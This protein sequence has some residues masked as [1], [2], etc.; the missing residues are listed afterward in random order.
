MAEKGATR[1]HFE[2]NEALLTDTGVTSL[3][4]YQWKDKKPLSMELSTNEQEHMN[5]YPSYKNILSY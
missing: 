2:T 5:R 1:A 3:F 4:P